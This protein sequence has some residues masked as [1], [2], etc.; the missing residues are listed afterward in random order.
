[1]QTLF[2]KLQNDL[3]HLPTATTSL[4]QYAYDT[5]VIT[6]THARNIKLIMIAF[7]VFG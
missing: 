1:M 7:N 6:P 5:V 3:I 2:S 4:L